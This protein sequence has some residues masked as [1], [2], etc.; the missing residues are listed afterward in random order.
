MTFACAR[1]GV[2]STD[3]QLSRPE[4]KSCHGG[5]TRISPFP[6]QELM[7]FHAVYDFS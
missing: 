7:S 2:I 3:A 4:A 6:A 1:R 5:P